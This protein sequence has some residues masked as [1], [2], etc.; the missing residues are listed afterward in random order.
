MMPRQ[1][2]QRLG[3]DQGA[4]GGIADD[5]L[6]EQVFRQPKL[7][8]GFAQVLAVLGRVQGGNPCGLAATHGSLHPI[9][10]TAR[11]ERQ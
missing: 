6:D 1:G 9:R 11:R 7:G 10:L 5:L 8:I 3:F 2:K 4:A